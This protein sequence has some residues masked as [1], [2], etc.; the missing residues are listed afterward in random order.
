MNSKIWVWQNF[1]LK[2]EM[3]LFGKSV[4][5]VKKIDVG[6]SIDKSK[7]E[8]PAG[9]TWTETNFNAGDPA[10][11]SLG[12]GLEKGLNDLKDMFGPKKKK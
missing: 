8:I 9:I 11:D 12:K 1:A 10:F 7:F 5:E 2:T 6:G 4:I 3:N